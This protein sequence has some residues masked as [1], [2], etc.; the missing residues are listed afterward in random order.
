MVLQLNELKNGLE[1]QKRIELRHLGEV[2]LHIVN[3]E[4]ATAQR[5]TVTMEQAQKN[6]AARIGALRYGSGDYF[7]INDMQPRMVMHPIK[8][9]LNGTRR[10]RTCKDPSGK[11]L[12]V[13]FVD[14]VKRQGAGF[15]AYQWPKPGAAGPQPKLSYV[16]GFEP[17]GWVIGTGVYIDD[18][19][20]QVWSSAKRAVTIGSIIMRRARRRHDLQRAPHVGGTQGHDKGDGRVGG[21]KFRSGAAG[22]GRKDEIGDIAAAVEAFKHKAI[23]R[24]HLD[25]EAEAQRRQREVDEAGA[26]NGRAGAHVKAAEER[27][28]TSE[29]LARMMSALASE[30][31]AA[32]RPVI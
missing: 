25:S 22:L 26:A 3:E 5:G 7:W 24:A 14:V 32:C 23:E 27:G 29:E 28:K 1:D 2:A 30:P 9:E 31:A 20:E 17:W 4:Y 11:R 21:W 13:E 15:V 12:F 16:A 19:Q 6:A 8:P 10:F 18:L